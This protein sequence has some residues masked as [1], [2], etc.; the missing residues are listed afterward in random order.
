MYLRIALCILLYPLSL[1]G[2]LKPSASV[3]RE[4]VNVVQARVGDK[5]ATIRHRS[6]KKEVLPVNSLRLANL[7]WFQQI[8]A[9]APLHR[10]NA[11]IHEVAPSVKVYE[12]KQTIVTAK[13]EDGIETVQL[14]AP[15]VF[16]DQIGG[17]CMFYARV[18]LMDIAGYYVNNGTIFKVINGAPPNNPWSSP[19]YVNGLSTII[20]DHTPTPIT[21]EA[22]PYGDNFEWARQQL[23]LG[24]P[25]LAA[26]PSE[27][28]Q[29]LPSGYL[30]ERQWSGGDVG[31]Q[32]VVNGFTFNPKT[33]EGSFHVINS[34]E[35]LPEF[36]LKLKDAGRGILVFEKS[37][38]PIGHVPDYAE[39]ERL[40]KELKVLKV[41]LLRK[42]G[43]YNLYR[44]VTNQGEQRIMAPDAFTAQK[45][46][47]EEN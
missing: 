15:N 16:R 14:C 47:E 12:P 6:G 1:Y 10:G 11:S 19:N 28:W 26:L 30:A 7:D 33:G 25:I 9:V 13:I 23:R 2:A 44:V 8:E 38:S 22:L 43:S 5:Y 37:V 31:H 35:E 36:D 18:H 3:S 27:I 4:Y 34:W 20:T 29:A 21:H 46:V 40:A 42:A 41:T 45:I 32:I 39:Q 17:T 24:R